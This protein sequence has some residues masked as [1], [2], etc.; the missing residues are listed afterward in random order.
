MRSIT[1][2]VILMV[3]GVIPLWAG[4]PD[5]LWTRTFGGT[6]Y[7]WPWHVEETSDSG[8]VIT[9]Y[10]GT[11]T[12]GY[13]HAYIVK[14]RQDGDSVWSRTFGTEGHETDACSAKET[15]DGG[16]IV[17]GYGI[18]QFGVT[19]ADFYLMKLDSWGNLVWDNN[20]D[21]D[22]TTDYG[23]DV[24]QTLD[25]GFIMV[26]YSYYYSESQEEYDWGINIV[27]TDP[28]GVKTNHV[29]LDI[30][31]TQDL[32]RVIATSDSGA[33]AVGSAGAIY[34]VKID[35]LGNIAW[36]KGYGGTGAG[37]G[38]LELPEGGYM[39]FGDRGYNPPENDDFW[40]LRLDTL[41]DTLWSKRYRNPADNSGY[42]LDQ[43]AD[44]GF[45]MTGDM[46]RN[47]GLDPKDIY[48][49][50]TDANGDTLWTKTIGGDRYEYSYCIKQTFDGGY[51]IAGR[52][53]S[54]GAGDFDFYVVKLAPDNPSAVDDAEEIR[55]TSFSLSA[56]Y[57]N[58]F[59]PGTTIEY[60]LDRRA[61]VKIE[62]FN[63]LGQAVRTLVDETKPAGS[64]QTEWDGA[65][66]SGRPVPTGVYLYRMQTDGLAQ[67]KKMLLLK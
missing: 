48:V 31:G 3:L 18:G 28:L 35:K 42:G 20:Y 23:F 4:P 13:R 67:A 5:V 53:N 36:R 34:I 22:T 39:A 65:D 32:N 10:T 21:Y 1:I 61:H 30:P 44:G 26:G 57:P 54:Y 58:P 43:T 25:G 40:L 9:G 27:R 16:L 33:I 55:P 46:Y 56:N 50:R 14:L 17:A 15:S 49:I 59:N 51:I 62:I 11:T 63:I 37:W 38:I 7:E 47:G 41:G 12:D 45:V 60:M 64:Y 6:S 24:C 19:G 66:D 29:L 52:T 2:A 8:Y